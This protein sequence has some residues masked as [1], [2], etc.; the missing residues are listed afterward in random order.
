MIQR[1]KSALPSVT[2]ILDMAGL[3]DYYNIPDKEYYF[4]LG[5]A[6]DYATQLVD[7]DNLGE[8]EEVIKPYVESY[9][10]FLKETKCE[11]LENQ[12]H[13]LSEIYGFQGT[14]DKKV[15]LNGY[16]A[17]I[18]VKCSEVCYP[19]YAWQTAGYMIAYNEKHKRPLA[20]QKRYVLNLTK[21]G[22]KLTPCKDD[23]DLSVFKAAVVIAKARKDNKLWKPQNS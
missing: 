22:Y 9:R 5:R 15:K 11:V 13:V 6:V 7:E 12:V 18:D 21:T 16:W 14:L 23:N 1:Y 3:T 2:E 19:W 4:S 17:V 8:C 20:I 10:K